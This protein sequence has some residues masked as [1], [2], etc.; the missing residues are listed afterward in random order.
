MK[1]VEEGKKQVLWEENE[2][3]SKGV[4]QTSQNPPDPTQPTGLGRFVRVSGLGCKFFFFLNSR[5]D[6][7][8]A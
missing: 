2:V 8:Q 7:V 3:G 5:L 4:Q 1:V 6:W